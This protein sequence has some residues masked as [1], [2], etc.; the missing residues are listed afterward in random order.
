[1]P[2]GVFP[3]K[4]SEYSYK[5]PKANGGGYDLVCE[6]HLNAS[7]GAGHGVEVFYYPEIKRQ[8]Y[9]KPYMQEYQ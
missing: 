9:S 6:L 4:E 7:D 2:G 8:Q 1:M 5:I 3:S